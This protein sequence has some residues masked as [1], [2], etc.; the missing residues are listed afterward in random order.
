MRA[1]ATWLAAAVL[2]AAPAARAEIKVGAV[3]S[4]T[5]P[6]ASLGIPERNTIELLPKT[7]GDEPVRTIVLD[8]A[9]DTSAAVRAARKLV[10]DEKV[11]I[12]FGPS[13]TP[14]SLAVLEVIGPAR[15]PMISLAG[16]A[17]IA[18]P[19]EGHKTWAFKLAPEE[20]IQGAYIF[21]NMVRHGQKSVA[22]IGFSDAFGDSFI[23]SMKKLAAERGVAVLA[24]ERYVRTDPSVVG[25]VLKVL[26]TRP[27]VVIIGASG[28]PGVTPVLELKKQ[29]YKG[30][31]YIN[32]GMANPDVLRV[33]GAELNG[34]LMPVSP[35]LVAEQLRDDNPIKPVALQYTKAYEAVHGA[36]S[37]NL[38]GATVWDAF[39]ITAAALP[40]AKAAAKPGSPEFRTA[41]RDA[42][43]E[44][45]NLVGAQAVFSM[46][47]TDHNGT[48][49]RAQVLVRIEGGGWKYMP[50]D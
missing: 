7:I 35:V 20:R 33:G 10:D 30:Q 15:T 21:D 25:Q 14:T 24:D 27:D 36:N 3:L 2:A 4:L 32:Q 41:L 28:T 42:I 34:V 48:D 45:S 5:G 39:L 1:L 23:G 22:F 31:I 6:A 50:P 40:K 11:D 9:S 46:S 8:D 44:T 47:P 17:V 26:A 49:K 43:Q 13:V 18:S 29:G 12:L 19:V 38:F 16:S 37:R